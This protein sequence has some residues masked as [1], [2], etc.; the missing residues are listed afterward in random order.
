[1]F[2]S[3]FRDVPLLAEDNGLKTLRFLRLLGIFYPQFYGSLPFTFSVSMLEGCVCL[4]VAG[5]LLWVFSK[6]AMAGFLEDV[7]S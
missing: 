3:S 4:F 6:F 2:G 7:C 5:C 1:M